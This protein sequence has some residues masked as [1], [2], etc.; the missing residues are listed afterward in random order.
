MARAGVLHG[1]AYA[2]CIGGV[3]EDGLVAKDNSGA[4]RPCPP[5]L[6][7]AALLCAAAALITASARAGE[8]I[9]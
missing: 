1:G 6:L 9:W 5:L 3:C 2:Y 4:F 7:I 8:A